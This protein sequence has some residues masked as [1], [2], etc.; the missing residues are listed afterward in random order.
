MKVFSG[1]LLKISVRSVGSLAVRH[2]SL[3]LL[4]VQLEALLD[5]FILQI[6]AALHTGH[7]L[8]QTGP[9]LLRQA[10]VAAETGKLAHM[11]DVGGGVILRGRCPAVD[12]VPDAAQ[13]VL[14][15]IGAQQAEGST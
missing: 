14:S 15:G 10:L 3:T 6:H 9:V 7:G 12:D 5:C 11:A 13:S 4:P 2:R 8:H 1:F